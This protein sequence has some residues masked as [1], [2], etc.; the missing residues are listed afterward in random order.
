MNAPAYAKINLGLHIVGIRTD[1]FHNIETIFHRINLRDEIS[2]LPSDSISISCTDPAVPTD[3]TN[4]C[5]KAV[6]LLRDALGISSGAAVTIHKTIPLG[7]GLGG[8]SS[9]A[10]TVLRLLPSVWGTEADSA[11]LAAVA[12]NVGSD[13][14]F[15]LQ[16]ATAYAEGRGELLTPCPLELPYWILLVNPDIHIAT[17]WAYAALSADRKGTFPERPRLLNSFLA[18]PVKSIR[19]CGNDFETV[20]FR[21][22]PRIA[23]I[24]RQMLELGAV[25]AVMSGS[26][27]SV[28]GLFDDMVSALKGVE[29]F[30]KEHFVHLTEPHFLPA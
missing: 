5:W 22:H 7:A 18:D 16:N 21:A 1:G 8:G 28:V 29:F 10:A 15:F 25:H 24:K 9:D 2:V 14:P 12:L 20:V 26:G 4:H 30:H 3:E 27:S 19:T 13:V 6:A 11:T 23:T 17:P